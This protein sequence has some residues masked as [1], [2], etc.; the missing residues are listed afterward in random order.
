MPENRSVNNRRMIRVHPDHP[1]PGDI[2]RAAAV[3]GNQGVVVFPTRCLYGLAADACDP[4]A[5]KKIFQIKH[6]PGTNPLLILFHNHSDLENFVTHIPAPA[7][8]LMQVIW[9]GGLTLVFEAKPGVCS[10]L[11]AGT[12]R[13]G[14]RIPSHPVA[15]ALVKAVGRPIT[16]TSANMSGEPGCSCIPDLPHAL[17]QAVDLVLDAGPLKG[18]TG[19]TVLDIT[20]HPFQVLRPGAVSIEMVQQAIGNSNVKM[21]TP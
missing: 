12:G 13:I 9:P 4:A 6:R 3:I 7:Q 16:G 15:R 8:K 5:I 20:S 1:A 21:G 10:L 11:T 14:V 19:S 17:I 18:G 2:R